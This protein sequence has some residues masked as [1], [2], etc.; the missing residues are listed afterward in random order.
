MLLC[1]TDKNISSFGGNGVRIWMR[2]N[3]FST[4]DRNSVPYRICYLGQ[5]C[6]LRFHLIG[7]NPL[8]HI[9]M[10]LTYWI[11]S[12]QPI[13]GVYKRR[14]KSYLWSRAYQNQRRSLN[15]ATIQEEDL[16]CKEKA[17]T[18]WRSWEEV[19]HVQHRLGDQS[20]GCNNKDQSC[21]QC[22]RRHHH[23]LR[24]TWG[25]SI[26][27]SQERLY[28]KSGVVSMPWLMLLFPLLYFSICASFDCFFLRLNNFN[29]IWKCHL[30]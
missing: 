16:G 27:S 24:A 30:F 9:W 19:G 29:M 1:A 7:F 17:S 3:P 22:V 28:E 6:L 21:L 23:L 25:H 8:I 12:F 10:L 4:W 2:L 26:C 11:D 18:R 14:A 15:A 20:W 13:H 5:S